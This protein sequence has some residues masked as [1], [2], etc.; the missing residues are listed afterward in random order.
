[1]KQMIFAAVVVIAGAV[2]TASTARLVRIAAL[3]R[4]ADLNETWTA[5]LWS[6][7]KFFF[8][9][10]K[11]MEERRSWHHLAIYWGFLIVSIASVDMILSG[12][13]GDQNDLRIV[14]GQPIYG[15]IYAAIELAY[16]PV[17]AAV[18]WA[19][20]RRLV[21]KPAFVPASLDAILILSAITLLSLTHY[22][23]HTWHM[24][25]VAEVEPGA[26][27]SAFLGEALGLWSPTSGPE[28]DV[29]VDP[30]QAH[31]AA[32]AHWWTHMLLLLGFLNYLPYSKHLHV[33]GAGPNILLRHQGQRG[34]MPKLALFDGDPSDESAEPLFD[35]WGVGRIDQF[36]W[37]SL[38][39][40]YACTECARCTTYC[41][42]FATRKPLSPMHLIHDLKDEMK[43]RGPALL[44]LKDAGAPLERDPEDTSEE[45]AD[46]ARLRHH[47][48]AMPP[49]V[50]GRIKD[51][52]LWACTTCGACQEV[53]PVF[54]EH[55][56]KILQMRSHIV[57]NDET[58]RT[59]GDAVRVIGNIT[60]GQGNPWNLPASDRMRWAEGLDV[61]RL[62][63]HPDAEYLFFVGCAGAYD[64]EA[65]KT[66]R[67]L[68]RVLQAAGVDF[69]VLGDDERCT[70]DTVRRLGDEMNFQLMAQAQ[71]DLLKEHKVRKIIT[72]CPHC[73]HTI[74]NEYPQFGGSFEVV[75]HAQLVSHLL[76]QGKLQVDQPLAARVGYHDS[77]YLGRWNGVYDAPREVLSRVSAK[78]SNVTE[79][80]R[81][82]EHGFCCG[83]GGG[84]MWLEEEPEK[85]VNI[86]RAQEIVE[87]GVERV[88]VGCPF[89]KTMIADGIKHLG[90]DDRIAVADL[91][92]IV[93]DS[94]PPATSERP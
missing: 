49:M 6:L 19:L 70:G 5:R 75:H 59:P 18:V 47:L 92:Q 30:V 63:D 42:A 78:P 34:A 69:A 41:P 33:M 83:A 93:A 53:C 50:G 84:R 60:E 80:G 94:L 61:P 71:V 37:K 1:M 26:M 74:K 39:D 90:Q 35:N 79:F 4:P 66:A 14:F 28:L 38:I 15:Y 32:E 21:I 13:F 8:G 86:D 54:I 76:A 40:N 72:S 65:K 89:C 7:L 23:Y 64:D 81:N 43:A 52:T 62:A 58:G 36:D 9:Q 29:H 10:R 87:S 51:E 68:V 73:L 31:F 11:V 46:V 56:L 88:A 24:A 20:F 25:A 12:L 45:P 55:P 48:D 82:R 22:G 57:L 85:R 16:I 17:L 2:W 44:A 77:C 91:A 3:G 67:A 27:I